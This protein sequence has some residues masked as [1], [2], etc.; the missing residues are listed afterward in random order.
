[1]AKGKNGRGKKWL[2]E[3]MAV[4]KRPKKKWLKK[5]WP[6]EKMVTGKNEKINS[7]KSYKIYQYF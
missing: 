3:K 5:K 7:R 4:E 2:K 1:M 6:M